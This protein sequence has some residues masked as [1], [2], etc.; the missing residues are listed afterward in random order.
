MC[1][2]DLEPVIHNTVLVVV[3][4]GN[5]IAT[6]Y[7]KTPKFRDYADFE[8]DLK[9]LAAVIRRYRHAIV[10]GP[11]SAEM[12]GIDKE[13]GAQKWEEKMCLAIRVFREAGVTILC[14]HEYIN[15]LNKKDPWHFADTSENRAMLAKMIHHVAVVGVSLRRKIGRAHV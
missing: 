6:G 12:W 2:S 10:I 8:K 11:G 3:W 13:H 15:K 9:N 1:S 14:P 7:N 4:T 5:E